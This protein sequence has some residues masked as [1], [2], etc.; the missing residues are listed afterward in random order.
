LISNIRHKIP[1]YRN[2]DLRCPQ[3]TSLEI[4]DED[5]KELSTDFLNSDWEELDKS[6]EKGFFYAELKDQI[7][8]KTH[9]FCIKV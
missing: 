3:V 5:C 4:F 9:Y 7:T 6:F 1:V 8:P 2:I